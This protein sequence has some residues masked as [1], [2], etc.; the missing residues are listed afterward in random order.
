[1]PMT[2]TSAANTPRRARVA[3][4]RPGGSRSMGWILVTS[5]PA[6]ERSVSGPTGSGDER[7]LETTG[8]AMCV[9]LVDVSR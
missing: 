3:G 9:D 8:R 1:M 6:V 5:P 7:P 2:S 4:S